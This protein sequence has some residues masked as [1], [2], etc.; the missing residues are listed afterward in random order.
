MSGKALKLIQPVSKLDQ[1]VASFKEMIM[2]GI[3]QPGEVIVE[4]EA[5]WLGAA[6][7][8]GLVRD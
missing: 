7:S 2:S 8:H 5:Q 4:K 1:V 6:K 3:I